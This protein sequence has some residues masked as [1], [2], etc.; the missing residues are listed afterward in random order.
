MQFSDVLKDIQNNTLNERFK[1]AR[2]KYWLQ[3]DPRYCDQLTNVWLWEDFPSRKNLGVKDLGIDLVAR[4]EMGEYW[5]IQCKC[6]APN[7]VITKQ[8]V[9]SFIANANRSFADPKTFQTTSFSDLFW[10]STSEKWNSS[11]NETV[12][13]QAKPFH[14]I[15]RFDLL[16]SIIT[17]SVESQKIVHALPHLT[18]N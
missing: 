11:A 7:T 17:V 12:K 15:S 1:G 2:F 8:S 10:V 5:A 4:T 14:R 13:G 16:L 9:D 3:T 18:F 6:Y